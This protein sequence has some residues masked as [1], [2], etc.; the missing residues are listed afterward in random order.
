MD[1][2]KLAVNSRIDVLSRNRFVNRASTL[3]NYTVQQVVQWYDGTSNAISTQNTSEGVKINFTN[4]YRKT[5]TG[6]D[7]LG[8]IKHQLSVNLKQADR[9]YVRLKTDRPMNTGVYI[10]T[11][12]GTTKMN[13]VTH[14][15]EYR[16]N[17]PNQTSAPTVNFLDFDSV[18]FINTDD[19]K[20]TLREDDKPT[21]G[22]YSIAVETGTTNLANPDVTTWAKENIA[23]VTNVG[24]LLNG[25]DFYNVVLNNIYGLHYVR[26]HLPSITDNSNYA[27]TISFYAKK[28]NIDYI[29]VEIVTNG[30]KFQQV[31]YALSTG[32]ASGSG[33]AIARMEYLKDGFWRCYVTLPPTAIPTGDSLKSIAIFIGEYG[34]YQGDNVNG[35]LI[36]GYQEEQIPFSSNYAPTFATSFTPS[37]RPAGKFHIPITSLGFNPAT[38]DWVIAYWKKPTGTGA[39]GR[40]TLAFGT[41]SRYIFWGKQHSDLMLAIVIRKADGTVQGSEVYPF[42]T[43]QEFNAWYFN[44]WHFEVAK[45][46]GNKLSYYVDGIKYCELTLSDPSN[47]NTDYQAGLFVAAEP[48]GS[49]S[50]ALVSNLLISRDPSVWTDEYIQYLYNRSVN[51][52]KSYIIAPMN[53]SNFRFAYGDVVAVDLSTME[54][55]ATLKEFFAPSNITSWAQLNTNANVTSVVG[56]KKG[57]EWLADL[58]PPAEGTY[59]VR[60]TWNTT[61]NTYNAYIKTT[62]SEYVVYEYVA[63]ADETVQELF[64]TYDNFDF[65]VNDT[66][67]LSDIKAYINAD[68]WTYLIDRFAVSIVPDTNNEKY[69]VATLTD[70]TKGRKIQLLLEHVTDETTKFKAFAVL[71]KVNGQWQLYDS[72]GVIT[73]VVGSGNNVT[74]TFGDTITNFGF[75]LVTSENNGLYTINPSVY[76]QFILKAITVDQNGNVATMNDIPDGYKVC[77]IGY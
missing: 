34:S 3:T 2:L 4:Y 47:Y 11:S 6:V 50:S 22:K 13:K 49:I 53:S 35:V 64:I 28:N 27:I 66:I 63:P 69:Y 18:R 10:K 21:N 77:I 54:F 44:N 56:T 19:V 12:S 36:G 17:N 8:G 60:L 20:V 71:Q 67:T 42:S 25:I 59:T 14:Y 55:P 9:F 7:N 5:K 57:Y 24:K 73:S 68:Y 23:S 70:G 16:V 76:G 58:L 30:N 75:G 45:K 52:S 46:S 39:S 62:D 65:V 1:A 38:D 72:D 26:P 37:T 31:Y 43:I 51:N 33:G 32:V 74:V 15:A 48:S 40:N 29:V 61:T 41:W